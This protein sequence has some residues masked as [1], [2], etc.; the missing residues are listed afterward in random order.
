MKTVKHL[1][2]ATVILTAFAA[3][4]VA[5]DPVTVTIAVSG[6]AAPGATLTAKAT[7]TINDGTT[8]QSIKWTQA[9]G[10]AATLSGT[11]TDTVTVV[12]PNRRTFKEDLI[13]IL[14][15]PPITI[16]QLPPNV[17]PAAAY[18]G[19]LQNRFGVVGIPPLALEEAGGVSLDV[20][21]TTSSGTYHTKAAIA[22]SLPWPTTVGIRNVPILL[23]VLLHGKTQAT[24]NWVLTAPPGSAAVLSDA[25]TQNPD[26]TPDVPGTYELTV[27]DL[28]TNKPVALTLLAGTW[29]GM[30]TGQDA[31]G[32]PI[33]DP[34]C[35]QCH[36]QGTPHFDLFTPWKKTGHAEIFTQNV[37]TP[38][39]HYTAA[40]LS[41]HTVGYNSTP[42]KN[43]GISDAADFS[44]FLTSGLL[45]HGDPGNWSK[46][47]SDFP[48]TAR[49]ANIQCENCHGPQDSAA[50][51]KK[52][53][54]RKSLSSDM[55]GSCHGEPARHGR[56]Q[57]WQLSKHANYA[58]AVAEGT[59]P[60]C[61]KCHSAQ[62]FIAWADKSFS[63]AALNVTWTTED[64]HPQT[65]QTCH[66]PHSIGTTSGGPETN[67]TMR[68]SGTTPLLMAGFTATNVGRAAICMTCHNGRRDL[69]DDA[70]FNAADASR[71][72]HV[73]PQADV[74]MGQNMYFTKVGTRGFHAMVEDSCVT[75]HM[76]KTAPPADLSYQLGGT[77]H[78]FYASNTICSK[79]HSNITAE[80]VQGPVEAKL[81]SLQSEMQTAIKTIMQTQIR[82]GNAIDLGGVK[83]VKNAAD[84]AGVEFIESHGRQGVT[85]ALADGTK[86]PDLALNAVKV[87]R[88]AGS[89]VELYAVADPTLAKAGWNYFMVHS[90][91]S[92]GVHNPAF[93]NSALDIS[94][95]A[96]KSINAN[97]TTPTAGSNPSLGGGV[98]NGAGAVSCATP[99][100]Y[101]AEIA[102]HTAGLAG[103]QWRTDLVARN[104]ST[105]NAS[106]KFVLHQV[107]AANL[108]GT[109]SVNGG[110]QKAF[111]DLVATIGGTSNL[112][113]LEICSDQPLLVT[114]RIFN[115][116]PSGTFGQ[117]LDG[118][119]ADLGYSVGQ[120]VSLIGMRQ[121]TDAFR[122]NFSVTNGGTTEAQVAINLY[123]AS[124][125]SIHNYNL[126]IPAGTVAQDTEPFK[127]RANA[128]DLDWGFATVTVLK[129][130]NI[131]TSGSMIDMKTND[132]TTIPPKQ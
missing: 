82:L 66:D 49:L 105:S 117:N 54:S 84:I 126:T 48:A 30:I 123:D 38:N 132:P 81:E 64:V 121:K 45:T 63:T 111:E 72:P 42:L 83:T 76:E 32:R 29:K 112:G 113:S 13:K 71:A 61:G 95:F 18:D 31:Q 7:I 116:A 97:A 25:T 41:C 125:R 94:L 79:C 88:P 50:H 102:G 39:G 3:T 67:A 26:F 107:G 62:G 122:S 106:L 118:R 59:D 11:T 69:R 65:C 110:A 70:H 99:Y 20:A 130:T 60:T 103:S 127:N 68:V 124:G 15:E 77:N 34:A 108:E 73:G 91:K 131:L 74:L 87:V 114:G 1:V 56:F 23:P 21:V 101:W 12:L 14:E 89:A 109:G 129:G 4:A 6:S 57:Q 128:P 80:S 43:G 52:D 33:P 120:T 27:T 37:N 85:V 44:T 10:V 28:A 24:Y 46:I 36:V 8:L 51:M 78:T 75:C 92:K 9:G 35:M 19:G 40:C 93:V 98:G 55:C 47:L 96:V 100:V 53:G 86:V 115:Q 119:V 5:A 90:D 17:P 16:V 104:L 2:L 58:I 22:A